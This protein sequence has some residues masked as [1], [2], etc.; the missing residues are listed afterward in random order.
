MQI[1][2]KLKNGN[3]EELTMEEARELYNELRPIFGPTEL[4]YAKW[5]YLSPPI[6]RTSWPST[7]TFTSDR[8]TPK[9]LDM[10]SVGPDEGV[11]TWRS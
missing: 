8:I 2:L 5:P 3:K 4:P 9:S 1:L 7:P 11:P 10:T 6:N